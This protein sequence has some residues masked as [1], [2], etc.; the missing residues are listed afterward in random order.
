MSIFKRIEVWVLLVLT[1]AG[2]VFVL[3]SRNGQ[4][5]DEFGARPSRKPTADTPG[6]RPPAEKLPAAFRE[7]G[8]IQ[9]QS[10]QVKRDRADYIAEVKLRY[11]NQ[12][13]ALIRTV[14]EAKLVTESGSA[15]PVFFLAFTGAPPQ[16]RP[17]ETS[18]LSL[19]FSIP[20]EDLVGQLTLAISGHRASV[21]SARSFD[22][23]SIGP[24]QIRTFDQPDW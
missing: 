3:L 12:T 18:D 8:V 15:L 10:V 21:K 24:D 13:D 7:S 2:L 11:D 22:P 4:E 16:L 5:I 19:Q 14:D 1:V 17:K 23:E 6:Q 20:S 9:I